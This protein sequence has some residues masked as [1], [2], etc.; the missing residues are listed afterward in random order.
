MLYN[1][2]IVGIV[3]GIITFYVYYLLRIRSLGQLSDIKTSTVAYD[4]AAFGHT[5]TWDKYCFY[6]NQK[7]L[8]I[9]SG[10]FHYWRLPDR[11][12]WKKVLQQYKAGGLN[13]IRIYFHWGYH[14]HD[15]GSY[16]FNGN[17]DVEFLLKLCEE[18][19]LFVLA[20]PGPYICAETQGGGIPPWLIAK[21]DVRI[22][23]NVT[24]FIKSFDKEYSRYCQQW[25]SEILPIIVRH[26]V[27]TK[28]NGCVLAL[29]I[30]NESFES[31]FGFPLGLADDMR[32]LS[33]TARDLGITVPLF[34]NDAWEVG[35]FVAYPESHKVFGRETFG[36]DLYGFDKYVVFCPTS[37]PFAA[38]SDSNSDSKHNWEEWDPETFKKSFD[39]SE[40]TVRSFGGAAAES[41]ILIPELQGGWFNHHSVNATFDDVY[42]YYGEQYTRLIVET[43]LSQGVTAFSLYMYY[44]GTNWGTL[45]DPDV[46]TSYDYSACIREFGHFSAR[47]RHVRLTLSFARSFAKELSRTIPIENSNR[48]PFKITSAIDD[49]ICKQRCTAFGP[50]QT[51]FVFFRNFSVGKVNTS[52]ITVDRPNYEPF[53][54]RVFLPYK[55]S[56]IAISNYK[57]MNGLHLILSTI[58]IYIRSKTASG[59]ELWIIQSDKQI[60]GQLSFYGKVRATGTADPVLHFE[61]DA[62]II[63][64]QNA[65][66]SVE[67]QQYDDKTT[68][69]CIIL[70]TENDLY[71]L[72]P[73]FSDNYWDKTNDDFRNPD[74]PIAI[75][76]GA[77]HLN[78]DVKNKK[79]QI[80]QCEVDKTIYAINYQTMDQFKPSKT[81]A[82]LDFIQSFD[83]EPQTLELLTMPKIKFDQVHVCDLDTLPWQ[84]IVPLTSPI[85]L[86]F[87]SG[88]VF[89][90]LAFHLDVLPPKALRFSIN[91]R[92]HCSLYLNSHLLG[93]HLV[94]SLGLM[95]PGSKQGP[96]IGYGGWKTYSL[97][98]NQLQVGT[99]NIYCIIESFGLNRQPGPFDDVRSP[100]GI[101]AANINSVSKLDW[102]IAGIDIRTRS[103][104]FNDIGIMIPTEWSKIENCP[105]ETISTNELTWTKGTFEWNSSIPLR[106]HIEGPHICYIMVNDILMG[107]YYGMIG[108][109]RDFYIPEGILKPINEILVWSYCLDKGQTL[110][111]QFRHWK[112]DSMYGSG[113]QD[114]NGVNFILQEKSLDV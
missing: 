45:G 40:V 70:L 52:T 3:I 13:C 101:L 73:V 11:N 94:Y 93:G 55:S 42:D 23:H 21:K 84:P 88:H 89:Y 54:M 28:P 64:F 82:P 90:R 7:Q 97:P 30:E 102:Y 24:S 80:H 1:I 76:W 32:V 48:A 20:A 96:E 25:F 27:T 77:Y 95:R 37:T 75:F 81:Y 68:K 43:A 14:S 51:Y 38:F 109:Q 72:Y 86:G 39:R 57:T 33:K 110:K 87:I 29:Q 83:L 91:M 50:M 104:P 59:N 8:M 63:S 61:H 114:E 71:S 18:L 74:L 2:L 92:H 111:F 67:I 106:L 31:L 4:H 98:I 53:Q 108:P 113:N 9:L 17:R 79:L 60:N 62:T 112:L 41:P 105:Q 69:L 12:R 34:T 5:L 47:G 36:L 103:V 85:D 10:E 46:Y 65:T 78:Y 58:P 56:F 100:R 6:L 16:D 19:E 22:R 35:S 44:G 66:G 99:N 15:E 26:Q 107:R 49:F